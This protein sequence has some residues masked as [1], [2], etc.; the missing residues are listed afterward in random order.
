MD[1]M[2][3]YETIVI[4]K[5]NETIAK[6]EIKKFTNI[7]QE[8]SKPKKVKVEDMGIKKLAYEVKH[9]QRGYYA[10]FTHLCYPEHINEL[11]RYFRKDD[12]VLKFITIRIDGDPSELEDYVEEEH[13]EKRKPVDVLDIIYNFNNKD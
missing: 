5:P 1:N 10:V 13:K 6:E 8:W 11:D 7:I 12:Q 9:N 4:F 2:S 3:V